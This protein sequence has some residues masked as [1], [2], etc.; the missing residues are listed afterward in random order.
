MMEAQ[1]RYYV[2]GE[3][4]GLVVSVPCG[5]VDDDGTLSPTDLA[6]VC[7]VGHAAAVA[8]Y[9]SGTHLICI[10]TV[11]DDEVYRQSGVLTQAGNLVRELYPVLGECIFQM[12]AFTMPK[13]ASQQ[14]IDDYNELIEKLKNFKRYL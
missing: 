12:L 14:F 6:A 9:G 13:N 8:H 10:V 3:D 11:Y 7:Q 2:E 4:D 1:V 5:H